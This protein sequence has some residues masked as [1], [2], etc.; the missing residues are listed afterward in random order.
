MQ[1][2]AA[3]NPYYNILAPKVAGNLSTEA[4]DSLFQT[5]KV[6]YPDYARS[7]FV[8]DLKTV[9]TDTLLQRW[10]IHLQATDF[11]MMIDTDQGAQ[12]LDDLPHS[13]LDILNWFYPS[14]KTHQH[15]DAF[16]SRDCSPLLLTPH[17]DPQDTG[18][19]V[20]LQVIPRGHPFVTATRYTKTAAWQA[21][22]DTTLIRSHLWKREKHWSWNLPPSYWLFLFWAPLSSCFPI[23][24]FS[25]LLFSIW[26]SFNGISA[27]VQFVSISYYC[28]YTW[29]PPRLMMLFG[30]FQPAPHLHQS[31]AQIHISHLRILL[32]HRTFPGQPEWPRLLQP[33]IPY[34]LRSLATPC[35]LVLMNFGSWKRTLDGIETWKPV[36]T[37]LENMHLTSD[38]ATLRTTANHWRQYY[39]VPIQSSSSSTATS[40]PVLPHPEHTNVYVSQPYEAIPDQLHILQSCWGR[41]AQH[42][43][44]GTTTSL[45]WPPWRSTPPSSPSATLH[46]TLHSNNPVAPAHHTHCPL[47]ANEP[48]P[49]DMSDSSV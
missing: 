20:H 18:F 40:V 19:A 37:F 32:R 27:S 28:L 22:W 26:T 7:H 25:L 8:S 17:P 46:R 23:L 16:T 38:R 36:E 11:Y 47:P 5:F 35:L 43:S 4:Y 15:L 10:S 49:M 41:S 29:R 6:I 1:Q 24:C 48:G 44:Q 12:M 2:L 34:L 45:S 13:L 39:D 42:H 31:M 33:F 21:F 3:R 14:W 30:W 9:V